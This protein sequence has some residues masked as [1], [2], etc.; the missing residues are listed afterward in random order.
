MSSHVVASTSA[1]LAVDTA[2]MG[3]CARIRLDRQHTPKRRADRVLDPDATLAALRPIPVVGTSVRSSIREAPRFL[4]ERL[5][6]RLTVGWQLKTHC[7]RRLKLGQRPGRT[8]ILR[9][10]SFS[11]VARGAWCRLTADECAAPSDPKT[12]A[13]KDGGSN[14]TL[15]S[16]EA[17]RAARLEHLEALRRQRQA[18]VDVIAAGMMLRASEVAAWTVDR[19]WT[20]GR[21]REAFG[22]FWRSAQQ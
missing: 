5:T 6:R 1:I 22:G 21:L 16:F 17:G 3:R 10:C 2:I 9:R 20:K 8:P 13:L 4:R 18:T 15:E 19:V 7:S 12:A 14:L 11:F